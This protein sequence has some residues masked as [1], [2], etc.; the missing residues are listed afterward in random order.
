MQTT[1]GDEYRGPPSTS[2]SCST[3]TLR[4]CQY[5]LRYLIVRRLRNLGGSYQPALHGAG[6]W[7]MNC[8]Q[9]ELITTNNKN[10]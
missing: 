9:W 1:E 10:L 6:P 5:C 2:P 3:D 8:K 7:L 4:R